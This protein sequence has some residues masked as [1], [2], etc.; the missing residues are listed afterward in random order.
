MKLVETEKF[1]KD[2]YE[3]QK[4][5][6]LSRKDYCEQNG[7]SYGRFGYWASKWNQSFTHL[8]PVKIKEK[9]NSKSEEALCSLELKNGHCLKVHDSKALDIILEKYS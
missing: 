9:M 6:Q 3:A 7:I 8:I 5:S 1:W 4:S 2:H